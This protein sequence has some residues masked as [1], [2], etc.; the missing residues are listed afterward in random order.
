MC[1]GEERKACNFPLPEA[2]LILL[3][4]NQ[5]V[6]LLSLLCQDVFAVEKVGVGNLTVELRQFFL[7]DAHASA[8]C[9]F[10]HLAFRCKTFGVLC[11]QVN[12]LLSDGLFA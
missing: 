6:F 10:A 3:H 11:Q 5:E 12:G 9:E 7:V 2:Q 4:N 8:L 1:S